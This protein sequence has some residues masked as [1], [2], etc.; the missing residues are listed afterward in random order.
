MSTKPK[1]QVGDVSMAGFL[2]VAGAMAEIIT[3][4]HSVAAWD[5][6][7]PSGSTT[8]PG[9]VYVHCYTVDARAR[10]YGSFTSGN[11]A[12]TAPTMTSVVICHAQ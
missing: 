12:S 10:V 3:P 2:S 6:V 8:V 1:S 5:V 4:S 7:S 9:V 11:R